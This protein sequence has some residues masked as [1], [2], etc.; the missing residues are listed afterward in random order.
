MASLIPT[1]QSAAL[2]SHNVGVLKKNNIKTKDILNLGVTNIVG[3]KLI[4]ATAGL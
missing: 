3:T 1:I 2:V 4:Q